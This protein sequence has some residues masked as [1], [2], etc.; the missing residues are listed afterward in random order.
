MNNQLIFFSNIYIYNL[1]QTGATP[2]AKATPNGMRFIIAYIYNVLRMV[3]DDMRKRKTISF[4]VFE[5]VYLLSKMDEACKPV[6][7]FSVQCWVVK[8]G[9][10]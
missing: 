8:M 9:C 2:I 10:S 1:P 4:C 6:M 7:D 5:I 3:F